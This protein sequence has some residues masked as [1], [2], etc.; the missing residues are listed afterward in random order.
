MVEP[1][2]VDVVHPVDT[3]LIDLCADDNTWNYRDKLYSA[4]SPIPTYPYSDP[5]LTYTEHLRVVGT[6]KKGNFHNWPRSHSDPEH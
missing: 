3:V 6:L 2:M 5:D 1:G 4:K